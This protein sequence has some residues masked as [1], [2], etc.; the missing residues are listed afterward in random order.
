MEV[1]SKFCVIALILCPEDIPVY[2][3]CLGT[4]YVIV[5]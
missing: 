4:V 5:L 2:F 3:K 1:K